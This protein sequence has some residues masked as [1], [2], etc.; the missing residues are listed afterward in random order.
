MCFRILLSCCLTAVLPALSVLAAGPASSD[1][2]YLKELVERATVARL[3]DQREWHVLLHYQPNLFGK[4]V[5]SMQDDPGFF[6]APTGKTDPQ[7][8]LTATLAQFFSDELVGRSKQ[9]AQCAF[10]ARYHWLKEQL[11]FD[12]RRLTPQPC[13]RFTR[14]FNEFNPQSISVIFPTGFMNNPASMFGHTFLRIDSKGQ[15]PQTRILDYTINY[16]AE[17]PPNAGPEYAIKGVFGGYR[18]HFSTIP[19]YLKVQEYRD[20]ENRDIWEY[21]LDL[22][23]EQVRRLL[24]HTWEMGNAYFDYFFFDE[25]CSFH[26]LGLVE[27]AEPSIHLLDRFPIY[28]IPVDTVKLLTESGLVA[29]V[30]SRPSRSTLVRRKRDAMNNEERGWLNRLVADPA[31]L[32]SEGFG[33]LSP[34]RQAFVLE[35]ASDYLL[36]RGSGGHE[37]GGPFRERNKT[38]LAARSRLKVLPT[39]VPIEPY[40]KRPD[41][42]HGT[43]RIGIGAGWRN[44]RAF[45]ELNIRAAYHDL[46]DPEY[47]YTPDAQ[48]EVMSLAVRHYHNAS[49]A[50]IERFTPLSMV[51][52]APMDS[53]FQAPSWKLALGMNTIAHGGCQLC[54]NGYLNGGLGGAVE[55]R[56][57]GRQVWY[58]MGEVEADASKAYEDNYRIGGGGTVGLLADLTDR[59]KL[60]ATGSYL[61]YAL[62]EKSEDFRWSVGQRYSL[63]RNLTFRVEYNHRSH[64]NDVLATFQMYF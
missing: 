12:E 64:D 11:Q 5:T 63:T 42:G 34:E 14:W 55:S 41:L 20:I 62:G 30:V 49:Q 45:E 60:L 37:E 40:V 26:I 17:V 9:P 52:L 15:T 13:E 23:Q 28:A 31:A 25:N 6:M 21:R 43:S 36:M 51:S 7:A 58:A 57:I 47:G 4:G 29:E 53:L 44:D 1:D 32:R 24:M 27:A 18:G 33:G 10:I 56:V 22:T 59:W 48:I 38:I 3:A 39:D 2:P 61:R 19:Y 8:E 35:T 16:A 54:T 50:R 46:L